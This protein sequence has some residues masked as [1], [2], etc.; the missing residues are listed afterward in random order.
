MVRAML[1]VQ[2]LLLLVASQSGHDE[3]GGHAGRA[4]DK[5]IEV[6]SCRRVMEAWEGGVLNVSTRAS[7]GLMSLSL[8]GVADMDTDVEMSRVGVAKKKKMSPV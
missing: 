3:F 4:Q 5:G 8:R 7:E 1:R 6:G 2:R